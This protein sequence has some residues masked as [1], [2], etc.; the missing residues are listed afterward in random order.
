MKVFF[1]KPWLQ[2]SVLL[3]CI[4]AFTM[5]ASCSE[6]EATLP[7]DFLPPGDILNA[8]SVDTLTIEARIERDSAVRIDS[9]RHAM[10]GTMWDPHLGI[11]RAISYS[12]LSVSQPIQSFG[13]NPSIDSVVL[14]LQFDR[15][16]GNADKFTGMQT[17]FVHEVLDSILPPTDTRGFYNA[18]IDYNIDPNPLGSVRFVPQFGSTGDNSRLRILLSNALGDR[19]L[20]A[21]SLKNSNILSVIK[22]I[23]LKTGDP[24]G[25][26]GTG[27]I[28]FFDLQN[29]TGTT[30]EVHY[31][32]TNAPKLVARL[33]MAGSINTRINTFLHNHAL[34]DP[35]L[36][37]K[38]NN[39]AFNYLN[40]PNLY[41]QPMEG[42]RIFVQIPNLLQLNN[43]GKYHINR[44]EII[45]PVAD[46]NFRYYALPPSLMIYYYNENGQI[47]IIDEVLNSSFYGGTYIADKKAFILRPT[48]YLQKMLNGS[49][50]N[51]GFFIDYPVLGKGQEAQRAVLNGPLNQDRPM[52]LNLLLT[53][54]TP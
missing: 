42:I 35:M 40:A 38:L 22:G 7:P 21:D 29:S 19:F 43:S 53:R 27:S 2:H 34:G 8:I 48:L 45:I 13:P 37:E 15:A 47:R 44:A 26:A 50:P 46:D 11:T 33:T 9:R 28:V 52:K 30:I 12:T 5:L 14:I 3:G 32:N 36:E 54:L 1:L 25:G 49:V 17:L 20:Q 39:L 24:E 31:K 10:V 4:A 41:I 6:T 18:D 16:Y 23:C 51:N